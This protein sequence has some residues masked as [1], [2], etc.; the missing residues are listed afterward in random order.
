MIRRSKGRY[1]GPGGMFAISFL[2]HLA[3]FL[4]IIWS[5]LLPA[6]RPDE[7]PVTYVDMVTLPVA[8]P[9]SGTP[10]P[11]AQAAPEPPAPSAAPPAPPEAM[12]LPQKKPE[13]KSKT[14]QQAAKPE[15]QAAKPEKQG[16]DEGREFSERMARLERQAEE[17]RQAEVLERLRGKGGRVGMPGAKGT[18]AGSDYSSYLQSRLRDAFSQV[19]VSQSKAPQAIASVTVGPDGRIAEF[20]V[21]Q[22]SGDPLFDDAVARAVTIAGRSLLPPPGGGQFKR[23][24]RFRPEGVGVR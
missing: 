20:R 9:Q 15:Q 24:F 21:E 19:M 7:T 11:S 18:E 17:R 5:Q 12:K 14:Q 22:H 6:F 8:A 23:V 1:P 16:A 13:A 4:L 10:A 2:L 3:V